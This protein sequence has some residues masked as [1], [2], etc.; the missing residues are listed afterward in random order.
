MRTT[1]LIL[2][3]LLTATAAAQ[4]EEQAQEPPPDYSRDTLLRIFADNPEREE[5]EQR[6][7]VRLGV[8]D[9]RAA[10]MR[11]RVG[12]LPFYMPLH[13]SMPWLNG[14]RWPDPFILTGTEIAHTSRTWRDQRAMSAELR[15]LERR[16]RQTSTVT[17]KPE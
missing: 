3:L 16:L 11:W 5:E 2:T 14:H 9:I 6:V 10:G 12:Y 7:R 1:A 4:E 17:V 13:G 8:V 15:R